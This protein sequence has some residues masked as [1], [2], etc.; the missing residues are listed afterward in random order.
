M[1][2]QALRRLAEE[3]PDYL[4]LRDLL[5]LASLTWPKYGLSA[6]KLARMDSL[7]LEMLRFELGLD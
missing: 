7:D 3:F 4:E 2:R 1:A 5:R 6:D